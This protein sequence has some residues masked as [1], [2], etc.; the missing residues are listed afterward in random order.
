MFHFRRTTDGRPYSAVNYNLSTW[1]CVVS[2]PGKWWSIQLRKG[3]PA[4]KKGKTRSFLLRAYQREERKNEIDES[5]DLIIPLICE[6][7][8]HINIKKV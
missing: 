4:P 8:K 3:F 7:K 5:F 6:E 1:F 2:F